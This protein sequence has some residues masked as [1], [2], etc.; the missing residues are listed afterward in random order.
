MRECASSIAARIAA[1]ATLR[2]RDLVVEAE[3][4]RIVLRW[5]R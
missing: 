1:D 4:G 3:G 5:D 2:E